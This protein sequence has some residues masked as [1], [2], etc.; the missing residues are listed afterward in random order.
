M[1]IEGAEKAVLLDSVEKKWLKQIKY[2]SVEVHDLREMDKTIL[3][4]RLKTELENNQ[5]I[6]YTSGL[7]WSSLFAVNKLLTPA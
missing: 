3:I 6:T 4:E 5:F 2:L 1:D 7:H